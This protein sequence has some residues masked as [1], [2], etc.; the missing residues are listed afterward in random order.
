MLQAMF[1]G[2]SGVQA[3]KTALDIIGNNVANV[4]TIAFKA[5]RIVFKDAI[6]QTLRPATQ[7]TQTGIGGTNP[8]QVGLGVSVGSADPDLRQG[9]MQPTNKSTDVAIEGNGFLITSDGSQKYYTRDGSFYIDSAGNLVSTGTGLYVLGWT[10]DPQTGAIDTSRLIEPSSRI[11]IFIGQTALARA[12]SLVEVGGNLNAESPPGTMQQMSVT[13]FDSQGVKHPLVISFVKTNQ[14]SNWMWFADSPER[15]PATPATVVPGPTSAARVTGTQDISSGISLA[16]PSDL[17]FLDGSGNTIATATLT[18]GMT[19]S[20]VVAAIDTAFASVAAPLKV[21]ASVNASGQLVLTNTTEGAESLIRISGSSS[22]A[23]LSALGLSAGSTTGSGNFFRPPSTA[24]TL[25]INGVTI[26]ILPTDTAAT[27]AQKINGA[28][29]G[30]TATATNGKISLQSLVKG[31]GGNISLSTGLGYTL[32]DVFGVGYTT[33]DGTGV[34]MGSG[35]IGFD[36]NGKP[37]TTDIG[38][39]LTLAESHGAINPLVFRVNLSNMSQ[40]AGAPDV[41]ALRQDGLALGTLESIAIGKDGVISGRFTNGITQ[42]LAQ[43]AMADFRNPAGLTRAGNNLW[44]ESSNS[45]LAQVGIPSLGSRGRITAGFVELSN[46]DLPTE[47]TNMIVAQRGFQANARLITTSDEVL[48]E[49]VQ[50]KR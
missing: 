43:L 19:P 20:Q 37:L 15:A 23:A 11:Q 38:V 48:Q 47:F 7:P 4:N 34:P 31:S 1:N 29:A 44:L 24:N 42:S 12:T 25:T 3:H 5:N 30:V 8:F 39:S 50:L 9:S 26:N 14:D 28:G 49:L 18:D 21:A 41:Q 33:V 27:V 10:A 22:A 40:L 36:A 16:G 32:Q 13:V 6:S 17:I 2:V 35:T 46:V 45:G